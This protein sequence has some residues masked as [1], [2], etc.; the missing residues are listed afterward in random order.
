[1]SKTLKFTQIIIAVIIGIFISDVM[2]GLSGQ[3]LSRDAQGRCTERRLECIWNSRMIPSIIPA[4]F[5]ES[6]V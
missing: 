5:F 6:E 1:M 2:K 4:C 3:C